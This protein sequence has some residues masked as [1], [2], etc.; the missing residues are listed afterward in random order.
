M[1]VEY[2][3]CFAAIRPFAGELA[4]MRHHEPTAVMSA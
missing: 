3:G 2:I 4:G 1:I